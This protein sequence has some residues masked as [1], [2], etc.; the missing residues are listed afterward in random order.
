[1]VAFMSR[2]AVLAALLTT[3]TYAHASSQPALKLAVVDVT[4][5]PAMLGLGAQIPQA[6]ITEAK[7][8]GYAIL[9]PDD[10]LATLGVKPY[11]ELQNCGG[12]AECIARRLRRNLRPGTT[13]L[14]G[15]SARS[16]TRLR[17]MIAWARVRESRR[18]FAHR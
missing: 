2:R 5:P 10:L 15:L 13:R 6:V 18:I 1:M 16:A 9:A 14:D 17:W 3:A 11:E 4:T 12:R 7:A 8:Q